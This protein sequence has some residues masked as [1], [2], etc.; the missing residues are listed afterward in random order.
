[1]NAIHPGYI[2]LYLAILQVLRV[3]DHVYVWVILAVYD[4]TLYCAA[5]LFS[6]WKLEKFGCSWK[7]RFIC[8][9]ECQIYPTPGKKIK[10]SVRTFSVICIGFGGWYEHAKQKCRPTK[11]KKSGVYFMNREGQGN[12]FQQKRRAH[13]KKG[14]HLK[15]KWRRNKK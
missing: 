6:I 12:K 15:K 1:M 3:K 10:M 9:V 13:S 2:R 8:M 4:R 5:V 11:H 14:K 7:L